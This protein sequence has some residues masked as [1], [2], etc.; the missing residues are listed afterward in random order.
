MYKYTNQRPIIRLTKTSKHWQYVKNWIRK[1]LL[2]H[3]RRPF[4]VLWVLV[5]NYFF[6]VLLSQRSKPR[7]HIFASSLTASNTKRANLTWLPLEIMHC[8]H[9]RHDY[10]WPWVT[11]TW[12]LYNLQF[13]RHGRW[14]RKFTVSFRPIRKE[15]ES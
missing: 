8:G 10:P 14:F 5:F 2:C 12:L 7:S 15:L 6:D 3:L 9:T 13:W 4:C 11:L 1:Q